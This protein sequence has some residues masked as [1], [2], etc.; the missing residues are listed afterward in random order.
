MAATVYDLNDT[1]GASVTFAVDAVNT[2]PAMVTFNF[3]AP[4]SGTET[5]YTFGTDAEVVQDSTGQYHVDFVVNE[6]GRWW[7]RW[8]GTGAAAGVEQG[9]IDVDIDRVQAF[10]PTSSSGTSAVSATTIAA[11]AGGYH[12]QNSEFYVAGHAGSADVVAAAENTLTTVKCTSTTAGESGSAL[13][14]GMAVPYNPT[15]GLYTLN[16]FN[17][18]DYLM[19]RFAI[20]VE[21]FSD[22]SLAEMVLTVTPSS[23]STFTLTDQLVTMNNGA[24]EYEGL[25]VIPLFV[26]AELAD[27]G[28]PGTILP[29]VRLKGTTG[30]IKPRGF[31]LFVWR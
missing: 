13:P 17:A 31:T 6:P 3:I 16:G 12:F 2:D 28:T 9:Y 1:V 29:Q 25:S 27:D 19:F 22:N 30:S 18:S 24:G 8:E 10:T 21:C 11:H 23:G 20:D 7:Y 5:V 15:T 4:E 14:T 26:G